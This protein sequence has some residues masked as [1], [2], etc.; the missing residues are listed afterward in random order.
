MLCRYRVK[1]ESPLITPLMSDTFFGHFC[2]AVR[3]REGESF[4][5]FPQF[6]LGGQN[7]AAALFIRISERLSAPPRAARAE[8][9]KAQDICEQTF[10]R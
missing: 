6:L 10:S 3:Y 1:T 9:S 4:L 5:R 8:P 7:R 2:W